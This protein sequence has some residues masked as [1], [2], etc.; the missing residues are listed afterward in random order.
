MTYFIFH[1]A[2]LFVFWAF[3]QVF[4]KKDTFFERN[5]W[6]LLL[7]LA[8][9]LLAPVLEISLSNQSTSEIAGLQTF[10]LPEIS[11]AEAEVKVESWSWFQVIKSIYFLGA[12]ISLILFAV[13]LG[14]LLL[15]IRPTLSVV[16]NPANCYKVGTFSFF[17]YLFWD[18]SLK[19]SKEEE[20]Q[21]LEH[22]LAHIRGGHSYDLMYVELQKIVFWFN[23]IIYLYEKELRN[24]HE[25]IADSKATRLSDTES[26]VSLMV[27]SLFKSLQINFTHSFHNQQIKQR[28]KMLN[29]QKT[30]RV[31]GYAKTVLAVALVAITT[32]FIACSKEILPEFSKDIVA[33]QIG[34]KM[35]FSNSNNGLLSQISPLVSSHLKETSMLLQECAITDRKIVSYD[36]GQIVLFVKIEDSSSHKLSIAVPLEKSGNAFKVILTESS[37]SCSGSCGC[38]VDYYPAHNNTPAHYSCSCSP[39]S[40][41]VKEL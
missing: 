3:Y 18:N 13:R 26:Y 7:S 2:S 5:R 16:A 20:K 6:Y 8:V 36:D 15:L 17:N 37:V 34:S 22:E 29:T 24:Q 1:F 30:T 21:I 40:M 9:A 11:I 14:K 39:C 38:S 19:L 32:L 10:V 33:N 25:F 31:K 41:T 27:S 12:A 35:S 28:I 23:P 4:L